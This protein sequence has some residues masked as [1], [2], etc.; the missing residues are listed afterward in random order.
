[1]NDL[2][3]ERYGMRS[4]RSSKECEVQNGTVLETMR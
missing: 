4:I 3:Y 1:M 2:W